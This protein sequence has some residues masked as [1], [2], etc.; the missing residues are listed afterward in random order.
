M[1]INTRYDIGD[2]VEFQRTVKQVNGK[3]REPERHVGIVTSISIHRGGRV[4]YTLSSSYTGS[5]AE[6]NIIAR[7]MREP[8]ED[9]G[10]VAD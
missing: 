3:E 8:S 5:V 6:E 2:I 10:P 7:L 4:G 9:A 1:Q